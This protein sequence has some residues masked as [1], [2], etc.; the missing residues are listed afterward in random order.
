MQPKQASLMLALNPTKLP[1]K[2]MQSMLSFEVEDPLSD[3]TS[4][5]I[6]ESILGFE[7]TGQVLCRATVKQLDLLIEV[8]GA[9]RFLAFILVELIL[10]LPARE[11]RD[12]KME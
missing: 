8:H 6:L 4:V 7:D 10:F 5:C 12:I 3:L 2:W 11:K 9:L 1:E